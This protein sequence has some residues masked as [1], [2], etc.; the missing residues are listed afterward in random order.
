M[1]IIGLDIFLNA[2]VSGVLIGSI[3]S[4][5][6]MG[7]ALIWG[8]M[9]I[10]N[11][12]QGDFMMLG[13]F[14]TYLLLIFIGIDP[15]YALPIVFVI[16]FAIGMF[17]QMGIIERILHAPTLSQIFVT[18]ALLLIIRY[19]AEVVFGPYTKVIKTSYSDIVL[20]Y[21]IVSLPLVKLI[22]LIVSI[23]VALLLYLFLTRT[24]TGIALRATAQDRIAAQLHGINVRK[25]YR[26]AFGLGVSISAIGGTLLSLFYPLYP[27]MGAY[28]AMLMFIIVVLGG[29]GSIFGAYIGGIIIGIVQVLSAL[30]ITP[31]LKDLVAFIIFIIILLIRPTGLFGK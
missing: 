29:F 23:S 27:E 15:L 14:F 24:Y 13:A 3:Y 6:A 7:L 11:F 2:I 10:I 31:T 26:V 30:F 16:M 21:G 17:I 19:G 4:L 5:I 22:G 9:D 25:M 8:V 1:S 28:F 18:F 20:N 12:A